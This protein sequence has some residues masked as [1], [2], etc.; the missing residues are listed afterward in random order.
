[1]AI[2]E[3]FSKLL[4]KFFDL[5]ELNNLLQNELLVNLPINALDQIKERLVL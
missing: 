4:I 2:A 3:I 5:L 1:M